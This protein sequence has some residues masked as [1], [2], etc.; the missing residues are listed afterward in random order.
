MTA[1]IEITPS[2]LH[3]WIKN[4]KPFCL[5]DCR[6]DDEYAIAKING[7]VLVPLSR[8]E[9]AFGKLQLDESQP[10]VV[11]CHHGMRSL[12]VASWLRERG[13]HSA[14]SM[15]GGIDAWSDQVDPAVPKY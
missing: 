14:Q 10:V 5:I 6:E 7:A 1:P 12:R 2:E 8:W 11:H 13:F 9:E 15:S 4:Q 3:L